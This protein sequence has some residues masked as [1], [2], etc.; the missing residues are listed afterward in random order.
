M[1]G[2]KIE[3]DELKD[4]GIR[5]GAGTGVSPSEIW[6]QKVA[7]IMQYLGGTQESANPIPQIA[8]R[9]DDAIRGPIKL[10]PSQQSRSNWA[11]LANELRAFSPKGY[12]DLKGYEK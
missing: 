1:S 5:Q 7:Q 11:N 10:T 6:A 2:N 8:S 3:T 9:E 4:I 12:E